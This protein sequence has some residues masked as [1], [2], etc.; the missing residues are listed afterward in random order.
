[1][2]EGL[3][4]AVLASLCPVMWNPAALSPG[5]TK[6]PCLSACRPQSPSG[7]W[8]GLLLVFIWI[9][10]ESEVWTGKRGIGEMKIREDNRRKKTAKWTLE[11]KHKDGDTEKDRCERQHNTCTRVGCWFGGRR[12]GLHPS[13]FT[14]RSVK[15]GKSLHCSESPHLKMGII[16]HHVHHC[17]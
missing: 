5:M 6:L 1:M 9:V 13:L 17:D 14:T 15:I 3:L 7:L 10:G 16:I 8:P 2:A 11:R 12:M 4:L